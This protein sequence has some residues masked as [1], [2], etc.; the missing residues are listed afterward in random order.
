MLQVGGIT[1]TVTVTAEAAAVMT[2]SAQRAVHGGKNRNGAVD[3]GAPSPAPA[4]PPQVRPGLYD[5]PPRP[6]PN[7]NTEAY[8]RID[9]NSFRRV[10]DDPLSTFSIDVDTASYA[11][12][13]R[14]LNGG[15]LPPRRRRQDRRTRQLFSIR[16]SAASQRRAVLGQHGSRG[17]SVEPAASSRADRTAGASRSTQDQS[18]A[19]NL[20]FLLDVS[21]SMMPPDK[22]PLISTAMRMLVDTLT[23]RDRVAIVVYAGASG[24]VLPSTSGA[25]QGD[26]PSGDRPSRG[27]RIDQ[28]RRRHHARV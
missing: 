23:A 3:M 14:F 24:L 27:R 16:L 20:V 2:Q 28:R 1:E 6:V 25:E 11:N 7:F 10:T 5:V 15:S 13:R 18:P 22:L 19:R 8:D 26:D 17:M 12:V 4:P 21:G 9:D